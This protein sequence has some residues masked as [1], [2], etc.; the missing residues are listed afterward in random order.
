MTVKYPA[1]LAWFLRHSLLTLLGQ[2]LIEILSEKKIM[3]QQMDNGLRTIS[4][5]IKQDLVLG[6]IK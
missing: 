1:G 2:E 5:I 4:R 3:A 6:A